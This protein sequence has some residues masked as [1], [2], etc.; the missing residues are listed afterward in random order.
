MGRILR[1]LVRISAVAA[2]IGV[3]WAGPAEAVPTF[4]ISPNPTSA[5]PGGSVDFVL[6]VNG[7]S[8]YPEWQGFIVTFDSVTGFQDPVPPGAPEYPFAKVDPTNGL[9]AGSLVS[10]SDPLFELSVV[11]GD[12][13]VLCSGVVG[14]VNV[15]NFAGLAGDSGELLRFRL[16]VGPDTPLGDILITYSVDH[17]GSPIAGEAPLT[18]TAVPEPTSY[19]LFAAGLVT[20]LLIRRPRFQRAVPEVS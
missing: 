11:P 3:A 16:N 17:T 15:L 10:T 8:D 7:A 9:A 4:T 6:S 18:I 14:C 19:I 2:A 12:N 5:L 20:L 1:K 13:A